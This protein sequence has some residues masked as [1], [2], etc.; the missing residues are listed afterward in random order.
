M[1]L[2]PGDRDVRQTAEKA[3]LKE[4]AAAQCGDFLVRPRSRDRVLI[5]LNDFGVTRSLLVLIQP[6]GQAQMAGRDTAIHPR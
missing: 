3:V 2:V 1:V 5:V 6:D 4:V